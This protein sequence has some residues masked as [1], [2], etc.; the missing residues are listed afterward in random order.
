MGYITQTEVLLEE[1]GPAIAR[2]LTADGVD[3][4]FLVPA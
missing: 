2:A 1:S 4:A 3:L